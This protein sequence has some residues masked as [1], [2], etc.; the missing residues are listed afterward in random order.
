VE[1]KIEKAAYKNFRIVFPAHDWI[2]NE[3]TDGASFS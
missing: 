3:V 2:I 1:D